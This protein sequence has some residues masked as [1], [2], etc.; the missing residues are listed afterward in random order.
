MVKDPQSAQGGVG[1]GWAAAARSQLTVRLT[2][3]L[4]VT[5]PD[6]PVRVR[7]RVP[8][9][10]FLPT[11]TV[12]VACA[13]LAPFSVTEPGDTLQVVFVGAPLQDSEMLPVKPFCGVKVSVYVP[14]WL[15]EIV[16][17]VGDA[18][19]EKSSTD[20]VIVVEELPR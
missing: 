10:V 4:C 1:H 8:V 5:D 7:V 11:F 20:C 6:I 2:L 3:V 14:E 9:V 15:R 13:E 19:I 12:T 17:D 16:R 18:E